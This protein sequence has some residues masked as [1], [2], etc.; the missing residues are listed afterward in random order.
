MRNRLMLPAVT[1]GLFIVATAV[2]AAAAVTARNT[3]GP[4]ALTTAAPA[5]AP[6]P[7]PAR[8]VVL[9]NGDRIMAAP[10]TGRTIAVLP[11]A[12]AWAARCSP[13]ARAA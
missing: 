3:P 5:P 2:T 6:A 1:A 13:S 9:L 4:G 8:T 11:A 12:L 10:G 7:A